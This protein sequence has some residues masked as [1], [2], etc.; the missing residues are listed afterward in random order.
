MPYSG[1]SV[2]SGISITRHLNKR[3]SDFTGVNG[4]AN[5][6]YTLPVGATDDVPVVVIDHQ[7]LH[8][9]AEFSY[10]ARI[11]TILDVLADA[12]YVELY[13]SVNP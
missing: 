2:G 13:Y 12:S 6:T 9:G 7:T 3:G 8:Y 11:I 4:A 10:A 5:R 1:D